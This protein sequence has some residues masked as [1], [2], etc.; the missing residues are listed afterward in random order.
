[1]KRQ[2]AS[3]DQEVKRQ[4]TSDIHTVVRQGTSKTGNG[5][6]MLIIVSD[7]GLTKQANESG[8]DRRR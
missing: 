8:S 7:S 1:M 2:D 3:A 6:P 5:V 4:D